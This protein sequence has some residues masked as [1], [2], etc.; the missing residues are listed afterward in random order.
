MLLAV[1][2]MKIFNRFTPLPEGTLR[3][4]L[5][6]L[7]SKYDVKVN[8]LLVRDASRRTTKSNAFFA[9]FGNRKTIS[10]DDNL[11][12]NFSEDEITAVF[13]HE[14]GHARHKHTLRSL[15]FTMFNTVLLFAGLWVVLNIPSLYTAFG[16]ENVNYYFAM[17]LL[18]VITWPV[19]TALGTVGN[20][21]SRKHEYQADAFAAGEGYGTALISALKRLNKE[22]LGDINPHPLKVFLD[23]S[24]PTLSQRISA[25][26]RINDIKSGT[27]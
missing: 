14:F 21:I 3:D 13:A 23:Y 16:F 7:C 25:I 2:F 11:I 20:C 17:T 24:H 9:G 8:K 26:D 12:N 15:P 22:A 6:Q 5:T 19:M 1:P 18:S 4:K 27:H 10:L